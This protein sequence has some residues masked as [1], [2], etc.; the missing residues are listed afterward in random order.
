MLSLAI[1]AWRA[2]D[3]ATRVVVLDVG[4]GDATFI[5]FP[6]GATMLLDAGGLAGSSGFD[7]GER[8]VVPVL[9]WL[10]HKLL[11]WQPPDNL[12]MGLANLYSWIYKQINEP[13]QNTFDF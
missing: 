7:V 9:L 12:E 11:G 1:V 13:Q 6:R 10:A 8:V 4:Q 5:R 2:P 3:G